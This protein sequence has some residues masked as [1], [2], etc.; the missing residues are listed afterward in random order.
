MNLSLHPMPRHM[1]HMIETCAIRI[2]RFHFILHILQKASAGSLLHSVNVL[3]QIYCYVIPI[4][5]LIRRDFSLTKQSKN[6][7]PSYRRI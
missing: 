5:S 2:D 3:Q 6:L 7:D 4:S 1:R